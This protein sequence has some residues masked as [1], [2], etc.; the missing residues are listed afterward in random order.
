M[1]KGYT[2]AGKAVQ[3]STVR[4]R[5]TSAATAVNKGSVRQSRTSIASR[6][7][8]KSKGGGPGGN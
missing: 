4:G 1:S 5:H 7:V 2:Q 3:K 8:G 6:A